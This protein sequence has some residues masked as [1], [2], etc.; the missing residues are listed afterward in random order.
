MPA[1]PAGTILQEGPMSA[2]CSLALQPRRYGKW[3]TLAFC[4]CYPDTWVTLRCHHLP[5][6]DVPDP[7][8]SFFL[9]QPGCPAP[10]NIIAPITPNITVCGVLIRI[11]VNIGTG[12]HR[13][14]RDLPPPR[15]V[16]MAR[17]GWPGTLPGTTLGCGVRDRA[18]SAP[19]PFRSASSPSQRPPPHH[20]RYLPA[21][22]MQRTA[23]DGLRNFLRTPVISGAGR[24]SGD[25][26]P[27]QTIRGKRPAIDD[28][29][30]KQ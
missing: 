15:P 5:S 27:A 28:P 18:C 26:C 7:D 6:P 29:V 1:V 3:G 9:C 16:S 12:S 4:T 21:G 13:P 30:M 20:S 2:S 19:V 14:V 11:R 23:I 8:F 25:P 22:T 10:N 17:H 24:N